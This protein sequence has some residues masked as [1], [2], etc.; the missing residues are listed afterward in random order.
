VQNIKKDEEPS[1]RSSLKQAANLPSQVRKSIA[2]TG[3]RNA[4]MSLLV[5]VQIAALPDQLFSGSDNSVGL[6]HQRSGSA[7]AADM[8]QTWKDKTLALLEKTH[9]WSGSYSG[10]L[11]NAS[12][13]YDLY[14]TYYTVLAYKEIG[15]PIPTADATIRALKASQGEDGSFQCEKP[16]LGRTESQM[17]KVGCIYYSVMTLEAL[18]ARPK[19]VQDTIRHINALQSRSG[20]Y[21]FNTEVLN[22]INGSSPD[23]N[24]DI[25]ATRQALT[26]LKTLNGE[27]SRKDNL[28]N[29][30]LSQWNNNTNFPKVQLQ[31]RKAFSSQAGIA[32]SLESLGIQVR[33]LP[34]ASTRLNW[35]KSLR[36]SIINFKLGS[37]NT[38]LMLAEKWLELLQRL[39]GKRKDGHLIDA[40]FCSQLAKFQQLSG[41]FSPFLTDNPDI[42]GTYVAA[43]LFR[44]AGQDV[45]RSKDISAL[46]N[47]QALEKGGFLPVYQ[48]GYSSSSFTNMSLDIRALLG[49]NSTDST[50]RVFAQQTLSAFLNNSDKALSPNSARKLYHTYLLANRTRINTAPLAPILNQ[51][52][53]IFIDGVKENQPLD[54]AQIQKAYYITKLVQFEPS[55]VKKLEQNVLLMQT[56]EGAFGIGERSTLQINWMILGILDNLKSNV[57]TQPMRDR[58]ATWIRQHQSPEGGYTEANITNMYSSY[59]AADSLRVLE[60]KR[61]DPKLLAWIHSLFLPDGGVKPAPSEPGSTPDLTG[62]YNALSVIQMMGDTP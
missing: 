16:A 62:T 17:D 31:G 24:S 59:W 32:E 4:L 29:W 2:R 34:N 43:K 52:A 35:A 47:R 60:G 50:T 53:T 23:I 51:K 49:T 38:D 19:H 1:N 20:V 21:A 46:L 30:L 14:T 56:K 54:A 44:G 25:L 57:L 41:G 8:G 18:G 61:P 48:I 33:Q 39:S 11:T 10:D 45:P 42:K 36:N 3:I 26:V 15:S 40:N 5:L 13:T 58:N 7:L 6:D 22:K 37:Q 27:P 55:A 28:K 12:G 9:A